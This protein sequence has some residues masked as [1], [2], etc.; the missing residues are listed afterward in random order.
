MK[1]IQV[2]LTM[3]VEPTTATTHAKATGP[4]DWAQ[5]ERAVMGYFRVGRSYGLPITCFVHPETAIAQSTMFKDLEGQGACLGMHM[6]PW[7]YSMW[8]HE[9]RRY[10]EDYGG[11]SEAD[12]YALLSEASELWRDAIGHRPHFFRSGAFSANDALYR[13]LVR[14]GFNGGSCSVPGR[15]WPDVRAVW[16]GTEPDPHR[17]HAHFR[18][19][20]GSLE[21]ANV[22]VSVDFSTVL[23]DDEKRRHW[24]PDLRPDTDWQGKYGISYET[25]AS[26]ILAQ[27]KARA[28]AHPVIV[29][30]THNHFEFTDDRHPATQRLRQSIDAVHAA[31]LA[32]DVTPVGAT[33]ADAVHQVLRVP[34]A[35][36]LFTCPEAR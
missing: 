13:V 9:S 17:A 10:F 14:A 5:G 15:L 7:K 20:R 29:I 18:H 28:P 16:G 23:K 33:L 19:I 21:F 36:E 24:H 11:L 1:D 12:Q 6:H 8:R 31:C 26:N 4:S 30:I 35:P 32:A 22:P 34:A 25:I 3:D 2:L 27:I